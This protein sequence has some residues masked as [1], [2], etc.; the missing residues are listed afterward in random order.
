MPWMPAYIAVPN[1]LS[2]ISMISAGIH[3]MEHLGM[4]VARQLH[5]IREYDVYIKLNVYAV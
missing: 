4:T 2:M 1:L 5:Y 3:A